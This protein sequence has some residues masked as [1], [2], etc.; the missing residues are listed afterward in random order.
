[1]KVLDGQSVPHQVIDPECLFGS[2]AFRAMAVT[3]TVVTISYGTTPITSLFVPAQ[4]G[5]AAVCNAVEHFDLPGI[6]F[7]DSD[8]LVS[9]HSD[10]IGQFKP[11][12][13]PF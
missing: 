3:T 13:H 6:K 11:C 5:S 12:P 10:R 1:M 8:E 4:G 7:I 9:K 2:L